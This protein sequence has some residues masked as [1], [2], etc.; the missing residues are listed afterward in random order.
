MERIRAPSARSSVRGSAGAF[1]PVV[2]FVFS[3]LTL[4]SCAFLGMSATLL[5]ILET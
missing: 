4:L 2:K 1:E 5:M 3:E